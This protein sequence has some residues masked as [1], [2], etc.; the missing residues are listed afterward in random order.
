MAAGRGNGLELLYDI[1]MD[2]TVTDV[3]AT[4]GGGRRI[5]SVTGGVFE[6]PRLRGRVLPGGGDWTLGRADGSRRLDVRITLETDDGALIYASYGGI[7]H[8]EPEVMRRIQSGAAVAPDEYY[9]RTTPLFETA[10]ARY[11]WLNRVV[12]VGYGRRTAS[13]VAYTVYALR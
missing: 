13:Q 2:V 1:T 5:V 9:F 11:D 3:G 10:A 7:F 4:P 6:G 8:A 12:A